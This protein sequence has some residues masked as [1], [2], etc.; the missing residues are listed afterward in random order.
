MGPPSLR[1]FQ[2]TSHRPAEETKRIVEDTFD[3]VI[4]DV[5]FGQ[6]KFSRAKLFLGELHE[7]RELGHALGKF[8]RPLTTDVI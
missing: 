5:E 6:H 4:V 1:V 8:S 2:V 7:V 3:A